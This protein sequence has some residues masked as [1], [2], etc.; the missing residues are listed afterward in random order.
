[1]LIKQ[2]NKLLKI[3]FILFKLIILLIIKIAIKLFLIERS[4]PT[5]HNKQRNPSIYFL[6]KIK[7]NSYYRHTPIKF[8]TCCPIKLVVKMLSYVKKSVF[9]IFYFP[10]KSLSND[11]SQDFPIYRYKDRPLSSRNSPCFTAANF[12][13]DV[14]G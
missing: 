5:S 9:V 8:V 7:F 3:H 2:T 11:W 14:Y 1:M 13:S 10:N 4:L 12:T 6:S